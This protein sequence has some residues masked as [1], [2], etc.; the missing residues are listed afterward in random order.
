MTDLFVSYDHEDQERVRPIVK[1]LEKR[2]WIVFRDR[3]IP[4]GKKLGGFIENS[5]KTSPF[6]AGM[7]SVATVSGLS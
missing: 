2:G 6:R 4:P 7:N 1:E 3:K 5:R